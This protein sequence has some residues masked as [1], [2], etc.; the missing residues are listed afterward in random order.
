MPSFYILFGGIVTIPT[1][2]K[3]M[4][5]WHAKSEAPF[6]QRTDITECVKGRELRTDTVRRVI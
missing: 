6:R 1:D 5:I 3:L 4:S 2:M